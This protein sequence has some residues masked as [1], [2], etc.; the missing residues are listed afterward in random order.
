MKENKWHY[1]KYPTLT[2]QFIENMEKVYMVGPNKNIARE[3]ILHSINHMKQKLIDNE[4]YELIKY[5][6]KLYNKISLAYDEAE[7]KQKS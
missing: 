7:G 1:V 6:E 5:V 2:K 4:Q 3:G